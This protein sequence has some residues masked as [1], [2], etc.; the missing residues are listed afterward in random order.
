MSFNKYLHNQK[1]NSFDLWRVKKCHY[2]IIELIEF[3][4]LTRIVF[5]QQKYIYK[6]MNL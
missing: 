4:D 2:K 1:E 6:N 5:F 3:V